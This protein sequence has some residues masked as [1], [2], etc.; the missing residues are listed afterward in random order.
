[1]WKVYVACVLG[2]I[3]FYTVK[4]LFFTSDAPKVAVKKSNP[5]VL[6]SVNSVPKT[7]IA[8]PAQVQHTQNPTQHTQHEGSGYQ[9]PLPDGWEE[10]TA[11]NGRKYYEDRKTKT[12]QWNRPES[13]GITPTTLNGN[14]VI[15]PN[16]DRIPA[17]NSEAAKG[18]GGGT[19]NS[20]SPKTSNSNAVNPPTNAGVL[21]D[22][23]EATKSGGGG[24]KSPSLTKSRKNPTPS[25]GTSRRIQPP[26]T[27]RKK[28]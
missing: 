9:Q 26:P 22:N 17:F 27:N 10:K 4:E 16:D 25:G 14:A 18:G 2:L 12:E 13:N 20:S 5:L 19:Q 7:H 23:P 11:K 15:S 1:M 6:N 8:S 3:Y 24:A 21:K 28:K